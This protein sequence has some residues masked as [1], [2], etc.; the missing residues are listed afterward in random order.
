MILFYIFFGNLPH[1]DNINITISFSILY[2]NN[3][4]IM[5]ITKDEII[6]IKLYNN[7]LFFFF[8]YNYWIA[9]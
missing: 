1:Y 2:M 7:L 5:I 9:L 6:N 8:V 4:H 3:I